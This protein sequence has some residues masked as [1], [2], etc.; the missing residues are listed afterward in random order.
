VSVRI[1]LFIFTAG[2]LFPFDVLMLQQKLKQEN[3]DQSKLLNP[4]GILTRVDTEVKI[5]LSVMTSEFEA[6]GISI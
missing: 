3:L 6:N 2:N 4:V 5:S 1:V